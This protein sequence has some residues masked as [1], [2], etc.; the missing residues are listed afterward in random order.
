MCISLE[1]VFYKVRKGRV[2]LCGCAAPGF[3]VIYDHCLFVTIILF[4]YLVIIYISLYVVFYKARKGKVSL[5]GCA[6]PRTRSRTLSQIAMEIAKLS[7][8]IK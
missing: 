7:P 2:L 6:A 3:L 5:C 4:I 8:G 1:V